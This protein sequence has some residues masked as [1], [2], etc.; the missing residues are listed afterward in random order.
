[1]YDLKFHHAEGDVAT[2]LLWLQNTENKVA[3]H[4]KILPLRFSAER[5]LVNHCFCSCNLRK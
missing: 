2:L 1:M 4:L 3:V 5:R